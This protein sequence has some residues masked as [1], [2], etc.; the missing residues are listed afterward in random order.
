MINNTKQQIT[1]IVK[2][3]RILKETRLVNSKVVRTQ[4][5]INVINLTE[6]LIPI[7]EPS[8]PIIKV[9]F[10]LT[11]RSYRLNSHQENIKNIVEQAANSVF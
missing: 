8:A 9:S 10:K 6:R 5:S 3:K 2:V 11:S 1:S 4:L 7:M